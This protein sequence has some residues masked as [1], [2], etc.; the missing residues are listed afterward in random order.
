MVAVAGSWFA[1]R[2]SQPQFIVASSPRHRRLFS[3]SLLDLERSHLLRLGL[4]GAT[5]LLAG[6][7]AVGIVVIK[8]M[9]SPL[10]LHF[11]IQTAAWGALDVLLATFGWRGLGLRDLAGATRL[12]RFLWL[13]TG[14]DVGYIA[15]GLTLALSGWLLGRRM[16]VVGAGFGVIVQ[17]T[18]LFALDGRL[19]ASLQ[20]LI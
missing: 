18:A 11:A 16:G 12:D 10:L 5:S 14:L 8:R 3:D 15:V 19:V 4:W 9:Q 1:V 17:G 7:F 2:A 20:G 13:N 6:G